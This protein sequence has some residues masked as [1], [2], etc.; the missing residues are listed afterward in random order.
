MSHD[1]DYSCSLRVRLQEAEVAVRRVDVQVNQEQVRELYKDAFHNPNCNIPWL[2]LWRARLSIKDSVGSFPIT[3][4]KAEVLYFFTF[5]DGFIC[6][7]G[8]R[9]RV[10]V[11]PRVHG[12]YGGSG[13]DCASTIK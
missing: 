11:R 12:M 13:I 3:L 7:S 8:G 9:G 5:I 1:L 4:S 10:D 6:Q 2:I